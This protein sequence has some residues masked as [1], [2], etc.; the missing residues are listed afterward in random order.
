MYERIRPEIMNYIECV[1]GI[2]TKVYSLDDQAHNEPDHDT[3][4]DVD[5]AV[6]GVR[7]AVKVFQFVP[8]TGKRTCT[9]MRLYMYMYMYVYRWH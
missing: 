3:H 2:L 4:H 9:L 7:Y 8:E 6:P 5:D 1:V